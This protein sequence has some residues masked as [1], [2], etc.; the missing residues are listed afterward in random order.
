MSQ[1]FVESIAAKCSGSSPNAGT[2]SVLLPVRKMSACGQMCKEED[3]GEEDE[4]EGTYEEDGG[5]QHPIERLPLQLSRDKP[6]VRPTPSP[7][8]II[9]LALVSS[10][11]STIVISPFQNASMPPP[12]LKTIPYNGGSADP[13]ASPRPHASPETSRKKVE[14]ASKEAMTNS[15]VR[16]YPLQLS[17]ESLNRGNGGP[18]RL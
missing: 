7:A 12:I 11:G 14:L 15:T 8:I 2:S 17:K 1:G 18:P 4:G 13:R 6:A 3:G 9:N 5:E 16:P 10:A